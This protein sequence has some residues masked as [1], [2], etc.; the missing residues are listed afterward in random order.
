VWTRIADASAHVDTIE[1]WHVS[2]ENSDVWS[3]DWDQQFTGGLAII[4]G[5]D[6]IAPLSGEQLKPA[7]HITVII[8][9]Y[10]LL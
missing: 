6:V 7:A 5:D 9:N 10:N 1:T 4:D 8:C 3:V 2:I